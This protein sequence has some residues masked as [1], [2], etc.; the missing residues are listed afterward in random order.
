MILPSPKDA[1]H[2]G[3]LFRLLIEI[4]DTPSLSKSLIFK[5]GT[6]AAMQSLL[7]RFSVDLDFDMVPG[8]SKASMRKNLEMVYSRLGL[9]IKNKSKVTVQYVVKYQAPQNTRNTIKL[10]AI[11]YSLAPSLYEPVY[12]ADIDRYLLCQTIETMFAHKLVAVL[13]RWQKH[14]SIAGRDLY[15]IHYFFTHQYKYRKEIIE[16][17]TN[18]GI[19]E[20]F[21]A[22]VDFIQDK[23]T[24]TVMNEDLNMLL[25]PQK[26]TEVRKSLKSEVVAILKSEELAL[27]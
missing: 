9:E 25:V 26:F 13:D 24:Q 15:D 4:A 22:L 11:E 20:F 12:L 21:G 19:K 5:G 2:R 8:S 14:R 3:Q 17:R 27:I 7:D 6:C 23:V 1:V 18:L 10:D 16:E